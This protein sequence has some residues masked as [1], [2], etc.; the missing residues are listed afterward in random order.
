VYL[1][2]RV[3]N[4]LKYQACDERHTDFIMGLDTKAVERGYGSMPKKDSIRQ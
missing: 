1:K 2:R 4:C 3:I